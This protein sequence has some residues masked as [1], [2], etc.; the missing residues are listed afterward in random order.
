M[1]S[2]ELPDLRTREEIHGYLKDLSSQLGLSLSDPQFAVALDSRDQLKKLREEFNIPKIGELLEG[3]A[4]ADGL[5]LSAECIYLVGNS[6]GLQPKNAKELL[7]IE[8]DK[9]GKKGLYGHMDGTYDWYSIDDFVKDENARIV[10]A[11]PIETVVMNTLSVNCHLAMVSFYSPTPQR[12]KILMEKDAFPSDHFV[13]ESQLNFHGYDPKEAAIYIKPREGESI[14]RNEDILNVIE[15]HGESIALIWLPGIHFSTGHVFDMKSITEAGHAKGCYVGFDLAH[16]A[17]NIEM[18]LHEWGVDVAAWCSYKYMNSGPGCLAGF[19]VH[20][21]H[22]YDF[23]RPRF[24][25]WW[26]HS[27]DTRM[28]MKR[29]IQLAPGAD[30]FKISNPPTLSI[31]GMIASMEIFKK[32]S[33]AEL[34]IK[35]RIL[36]GY[37]ELLIEENLSSHVTIVTSRNVSERG[38]QLSV[39]FSCPLED[40]TKFV[41]ERGVMIDCR[42]PMMR[43]APA[44]LYN[45]FSDIQAFYTILLQAFDT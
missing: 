45:S 16:A 41:K 8:M 3:R 34:C 27:S 14:W 1:S 42:S 5:D 17:G 21:K 36:T 10:G 26:A 40:I 25:G 9:W 38:C 6:L 4:K 30:G 19:F 11:K 22:A 29:K 28:D 20:E 13:V 31:M 24:V 35:S 23:D 39:K 32:T 43:I 7:S 18:S 12:Y 37:L 33:M 2:A 15:E 44:P